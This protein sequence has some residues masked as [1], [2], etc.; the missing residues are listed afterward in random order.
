MTSANFVDV[1]DV[2]QAGGP[3]SVHGTPLCQTFHFCVIQKDTLPESKTHIHKHPGPGEPSP[4]LGRF[5]FDLRDDERRGI[6][7]GGWKARNR[8]YI[9]ATIR[10]TEVTDLNEP[11]KPAAHHHHPEILQHRRRRDLSLAT[12]RIVDPTAVRR[13]LGEHGEPMDPRRVGKWQPVGRDV[14]AVYGSLRTSRL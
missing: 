3:L 8:E 12:H 14:D 13:R 1:L 6:V 2:V 11:K 5:V 9:I 10:T 4:F 7:D